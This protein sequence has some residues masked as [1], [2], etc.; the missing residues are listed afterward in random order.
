M[1]EV[2][3]VWLRRDLRLQDHTALYYAM[4]DAEQYNRKLILIFHLHPALNETFTIRHDYFFQTVQHFRNE[5]EQYGVPLHFI[6]GEAEEAFC[7]LMDI[8]PHLRAIYFNK[9]EVGFGRKRDEAMTEWFAKKGIHVHAFMDAHLHGA[10]EVKKRDGTL[11]QVFTP[12]YKKWRAL[13]KPDLYRINK[14]KL[15]ALGINIR[16]Q[17]TDGEALFQSILSKCTRNW[18]HIGGKSALHRL[19]FFLHN[20]M[21]YYDEKRDFP[22]ERGTSMISP[23][24]KCGVLSPRTVY[25]KLVEIQHEQG[26]SKGME[27]YLTEIA[28]RDFYNMIYYAHPTFKDEEVQSKYRG[29]EWEEDEALFDKWK[30]G[31]TGFPLVD[32]AMKQ[33]EELGWMHNRLR[34][35][36][37]SFLTKDYIID[38]RKGERYFEEMLIDYDA[39]SNIGGW[40]WAA[41]TGTDAVPYFRVFNPT[42]QSERFDPEGIFIKR[43]IPA[44]K[45]VP[46]KYIHEPSKMSEREQYQYGCIIGKDYPAPTVDHSTMRKRAIELF[47]KQ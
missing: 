21:K 14:K 13:A 32:A 41:S 47:E 28:W 17:L 16:D 2:V 12:Y 44:L 39:A 20:R 3:A 19:A 36:V 29:I 34:M 24:L 6:Q 37:A 45:H 9:D 7:E 5:A 26:E 1:E 23:Y 8:V 27:T 15:P 25:H 38:W 30:A 18:Q 46:N 22:A 11:Y 33:L 40:Q 43:Y 42:R 35:V 10:E 31:E 4:K